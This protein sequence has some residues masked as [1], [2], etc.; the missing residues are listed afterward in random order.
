M[1]DPR[2]PGLAAHRHELIRNEARL[3]GFVKVAELAG[4]L[5]VSEVTVRR[6]IAA[7]VDAGDLER[8]HG[9]ATL[10]AAG[11]GSRR[12]L[13]TLGMILPASRY[14]YRSVV[15]GAE[16]A[17]ARA[18]MRLVLAVSRY[19][20]AEEER[21]VERMLRAGVDALLVATARPP[22]VEP[23]R[24]PGSVQVPVVLVERWWDGPDAEYARTDH[25]AGARLA[26]EHLA[27]LGHE[28]VG[29]AV[30]TSTPTSS[31]LVDGFRDATGP[32]EIAAAGFAPV[33]L[34]TE[35]DGIAER[36]RR[37][38]DLL[39]RCS[40]TGT[41]G[42]LVHADDDALV[43][44]GLATDRGVRV[45]EDLSIVAYDDEMSALAPVPLTAVAPP[46]HDVGRAAVELAVRRLSRGA[47][48]ATQQVTLLPRLV[49]RDS[50]S[51]P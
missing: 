9:G 1:S 27:D 22:Q 5:G 42:L 36:D 15:A 50:T 25:A 12:P 11:A 6:D 32:R 7:L 41:R 23:P 48:P 46:K 20:V 13:A 17:A 31:W 35:A 10:P 21:L 49:V 45:P 3:R 30:R 43:L 16:E 39:R 18:G 40:A 34:A 8:V 26:V 2:G 44:L 33:E 51:A 29:L 4:R 38:D 28:K 47:A 14:Y 24:W 19:D 37:L